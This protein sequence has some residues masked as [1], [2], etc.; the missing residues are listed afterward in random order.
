MD[1]YRGRFSFGFSWALSFWTWA[2]PKNDRPY[3][4][5]A[6]RELP[7]R[8]GYCWQRLMR[9]CYGCCWRWPCLRRVH[10]F[11]GILCNGSHTSK[12]TIFEPYCRAMGW[13]ET[14]TRYGDKRSER[15]LNVIGSGTEL[16]NV[17]STGHASPASRRRR[18]GR[19][20]RARRRP[21]WWWWERSRAQVMWW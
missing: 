20:L 10:P 18:R 21:T 9:C 6:A 8:I 16:P 13:L 4:G 11:N 2:A 17:P 1:T 15:V 5:T 3:T 19:H 7:R 12:Y 14:R